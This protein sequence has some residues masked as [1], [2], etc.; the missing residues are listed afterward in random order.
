M[1]TMIILFLYRRYIRLFFI[2]I[3]SMTTFKDEKKKKKEEIKVA[4]EVKG[5][6]RYT[7][8]HSFYLVHYFLWLQ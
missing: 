4:V 7:P 2:L 5:E 3:L 1:I 8:N 6:V